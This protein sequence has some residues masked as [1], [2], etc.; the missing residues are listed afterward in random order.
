MPVQTLH[1]SLIAVRNLELQMLWTRFNIH[2]VVNGG[3]LLAFLSAGKESTLAGLGGAPH[4]F[5]LL[6]AGLW[7]WSEIVGR[8]NLHHYDRKV[9]AIEALLVESVT[10]DWSMFSRSEPLLRRHSTASR[11]FIV[12]FGAAWLYLLWVLCGTRS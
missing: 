5:G 1:A 7:L 3:F 4:F 8:D 6:L 11:A 10:G 12:L 9:G 2:L